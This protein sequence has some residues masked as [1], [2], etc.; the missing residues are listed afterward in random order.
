MSNLS[1]PHRGSA[2]RPNLVFILPDRLRRDSMACYGN[3]WIRSPELNAL[4]ERS[5]VFEN[6]YVTQ[7]VCAPARSS[8]MS[9]LYPIAAGMPVNRRV[10][11]DRVDVVA[12]MVSAEYRTGYV[13]KWHLG[14][15]LRP[16]RGFDH[17]VSS[18]DSW[19]RE[20]TDT[21]D[22]SRSIGESRP[23]RSIRAAAHS[24]PL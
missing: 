18:H 15:E 6:C 19:W 21:A 8:I 7:P 10:M 14:D 17:W 2:E 5:L 20:Y 13:G 11:P 9:G 24:P 12:G 22:R 1:M 4:A 23:T 3:E 16:R